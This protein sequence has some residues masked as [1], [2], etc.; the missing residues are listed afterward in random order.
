[1][2]RKAH[3]VPGP[4]GAGRSGGEPAGKQKNKSINEKRGC[5]ENPQPLFSLIGFPRGRDLAAA[6]VAA[7]IVATAAAAAAATVA[8]AAAAKQDED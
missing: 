3:F 4:A 5:G 6:I 7:A 2:R 1:M 8:P